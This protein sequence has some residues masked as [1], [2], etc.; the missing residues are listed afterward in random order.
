MEGAARRVKDAPGGRPKLKCPYFVQKKEMKY[1]TYMKTIWNF[2]GNMELIKNL[3][4][5]YM[6]LWNLYGTME[7]IW[8]FYGTME[9]I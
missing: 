5:T 2:Y 7:F 1:G 8:N 4:G 9:L 6:E 3:Y